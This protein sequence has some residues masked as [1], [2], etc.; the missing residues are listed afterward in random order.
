[1]KIEETIEKYLNDEFLKNEM[2]K[3]RKGAKP[4]T[5]KEIEE[6]IL[7]NKKYEKEIKDAEEKIRKLQSKS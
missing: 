7:M 5:D 4:K 3:T 1:M 2:R 6:L